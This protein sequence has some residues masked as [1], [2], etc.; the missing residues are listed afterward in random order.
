MEYDN[1]TERCYDCDGHYRHF[2]P[3]PYYTG[4]PVL[5]LEERVAVRALV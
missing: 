4:E 1:E 2:Y 3:C 5:T